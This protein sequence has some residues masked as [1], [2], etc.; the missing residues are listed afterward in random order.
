[1]NGF[2][3]LKNINRRISLWFNDPN[4]YI[5]I[6]YERFKRDYIDTNHEN[7]ELHF[8]F[9]G[10][11]DT[12]W[13]NMTY[14]C[15]MVF[16]NSFPFSAPKVYFK[17]NV[18]HPNIYKDTGEVCISILHEGI[19]V[20]GTENSNLRWTPIHTLHTILISIQTLFYEPNCLS[21]AN[22]D[23]SLLFQ[24]DQLELKRLIIEK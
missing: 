20:T 5:N 6:D 9:T 24:N 10:P 17:G 11:V 3:V 13:E 21:P 4:K 16:N 2:N 18:H 14:E 8:T 7:Y 22:V 1:M 15:L 12:L 23:A 19:D